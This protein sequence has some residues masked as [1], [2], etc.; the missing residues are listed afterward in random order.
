M[1]ALPLNEILMLLAA[2]VAAGLVGGL[3]A[4][5]FGVGAGR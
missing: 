2:L 1:T 4:G 5:L 3:I